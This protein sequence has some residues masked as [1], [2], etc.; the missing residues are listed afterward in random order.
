MQK[1]IIIN[2][3]ET[4]KNPELILTAEQMASSDYK[5]RF[6]AEYIQVKNRLERL[7]K[8]IKDW[9]AGTLS[10]TPTCPKEIFDFQIRAMKDYLSTLI[11]RAKIENIDL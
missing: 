10:F 6:I 5:E 11:I 3:D 8:M 1:Q 9:N 7:E 2:I 4:T